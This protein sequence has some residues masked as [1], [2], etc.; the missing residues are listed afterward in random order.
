MKFYN[1]LI[2]IFTSLILSF[3]ISNADVGTDFNELIK[4]NH[5]LTEYPY[6][7]S[8]NDIGIFYDFTFDKDKK[9]III[10]RDID[11]YPVVR[12]SL[13]DKVNI[14]PRDIV[15]SYNNIDLSKLNDEE[16]R[17]LHKK[18]E[19]VYLKISDK[20]NILKL[21]SSPYKLNNF[22]LASFDLQYIN[23]IDT[24]KG[25]LDISFNALFLNERP[26]LN[27]YADGLLGDLSYY[28]DHEILDYQFFLPLESI[29]FSEYLKNVDIR[30][31][32]DAEFSFDKGS[33][34]TIMQDS[35]IGQFRQKFD[36]EKFPFDTQTLKIKIKSGHHSTAD[37][38]I[39]WPRGMASAT[40]ITP[41]IGAFIGLSKYKN[42][43][44]LKE[45]GWTLLSTNIISEEVIDKDYFDPYLSANY[46]YHENTID[47]LLEI[48][49][50]SAHYL[51]KI[52]IPVFLIL[53]VAWSVLWIPTFKLD[54]RLTT[55]IV[56]L[57]SL[58]AYNFVF[59]G[60][61]PKLD[62]LTD[63]DKY[64]LLSYIF[65]CI[66]TFISIGFS[67]FIQRTAKMQ[68]RVTKVNSHIRKWGGLIYLILTFQIFYS[69]N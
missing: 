20:K 58:I 36:F 28:I 54:A 26:E 16:I 39:H 6:L 55:S 60:D 56:A 19:I 59:E 5:D 13:F 37:Q 24:T 65:C 64:I 15:I 8:R 32:Y 34:R 50:N 67:R 44:F 43:N 14:K 10:K 53:C 21:N 33:L 61:I 69:V 46:D 38:N 18:R 57:L 40:F 9:R 17:T 4:K 63:L 68:R 52:I 45:L 22:K 62:Y 23:T 51:F 12:F 11:N 47:V 7:E 3:S 29:T 2:S 1:L 27:K 49:R 66:P 35:G 30:N 41:D 42:E 31:E 48:K 25:V